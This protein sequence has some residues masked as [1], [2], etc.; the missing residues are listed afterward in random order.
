MKELFVPYIRN[1][2]TTHGRIQIDAKSEIHIAKE[3][4]L[5]FLCKN[6]EEM[7]FFNLKR[8]RRAHYDHGTPDG[9]TKSI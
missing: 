5:H 8:R 4:S 6:R 1:A 2:V 3:I 9:Q 7:N